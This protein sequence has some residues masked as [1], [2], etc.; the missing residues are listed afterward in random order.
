MNP[1]KGL[2]PKVIPLK[3]FLG[4]VT[5]SSEYV[6]RT[7]IREDSRSDFLEMTV[8]AGNVLKSPFKCFDF[9]KTFRSRDVF[10]TLSRLF[11]CSNGLSFAA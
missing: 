6:T 8:M 11:F 10:W 1:H 7:I 5:S 2:I 3:L 9:Q 4:M